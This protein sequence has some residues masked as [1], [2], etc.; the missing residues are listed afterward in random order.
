MTA[1]APDLRAVR[2][3]RTF[4][5]N[6]KRTLSTAP[7]SAWFGMI[8]ILIYVL[9]AILAPLIAPYGESDI[10]GKAYQPSGGEFWLGTDQIGRDLF[11]RLL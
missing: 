3:R 1:Q 4:L 10:V 7:I 8:V 11:S 5:E 9:A 6:L 2:A